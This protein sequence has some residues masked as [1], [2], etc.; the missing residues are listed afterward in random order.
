M[1]GLLVMGIVCM[2]DDGW[3]TVSLLREPSF[4]VCEYVYVG[5]TDV[6]VSKGLMGL[7]R[8]LLDVSNSIQYKIKSLPQL[9]VWLDDG[10]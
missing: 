7:N 1:F 9:P 2:E 4:L 10:L 5:Y 6:Y 3:F 8:F